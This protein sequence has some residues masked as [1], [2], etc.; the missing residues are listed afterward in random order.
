MELAFVISADRGVMQDE[1][2]GRLN[3]WNNCHYLTDY[4]EDGPDS[5][6]FKPI[7]APCTPEAF[8]VIHK[9]G[10][11]LYKLDFRTRPGAMGKPTL[12][13]TKVE[14]VAM[15]DLFELGNYRKAAPAAPKPVQV[16]QPKAA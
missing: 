9:H 11:G 12:T 7:K 14:P 2:T 15:I 4:R 8:E 16:D 3:N 10:V 6:G 5:A 1:R 13:L